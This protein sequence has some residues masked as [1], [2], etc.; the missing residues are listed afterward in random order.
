M[1]DPKES[2]HA[3]FAKRHRM[4]GSFA[5]SVCRFDPYGDRTDGFACLSTL[6]AQVRYVV[7]D[8][9]IE[10]FLEMESDGLKAGLQQISTH[11]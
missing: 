4:P 9:A 6:L 8:V 11:L 2:D 10:G 5:F 3:P 1:T 7:P